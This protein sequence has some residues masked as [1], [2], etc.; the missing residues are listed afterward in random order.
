MFKWFPQYSSWFKKVLIFLFVAIIAPTIGQMILEKLNFLDSLIKWFRLLF[1]VSIPSIVPVLLCFLLLILIYLVW[2][3]IESLSS[4]NIN[5]L[6]NDNH[7]LREINDKLRE[8]ANR[9]ISRYEENLKKINEM[10][11]IL[12]DKVE[13]KVQERQKHRDEFYLILEELAN[14]HNKSKAQRFL[15]SSFT[16][17]FPQNHISDFQIILNEL[18]TEKMI[19]DIEVGEWPEIGFYITEKGLQYLKK[20]KDEQP[21]A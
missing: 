19:D 13:L 14:E 11:N 15:W 16:K 9:I 7:R 2:Q 17:K 5:E 10:T 4:K 20:L 1:K 18:K 21:R 8:S 12:N 3:K 6:L